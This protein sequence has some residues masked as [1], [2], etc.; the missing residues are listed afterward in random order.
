MCTKQQPWV[1]N[2]T[3]AYGFTAVSFKGGAET[4][5][6]CSCW[7]LK[8]EGKLAGKSMIVQYTNTGGDL[9][10]NHF[11]IEIPGGG[12]GVFPMGCDR[13]WNATS[14]GW[15]K[16]YG[17]DSE[18]ECKNLPAALQKGCEFR[19]N[20]MENVPNPDVTYFRV[21]CPA[22]LPAVSGC[23]FPENIE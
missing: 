21:K 10:E 4:N 5:L 20:F 3:L 7:L 15:G 23:Q 9:K 1:V 18:E 14:N 11:D 22:E 13:Q 16:R 12:T 19:F 8:F 2:K 17:I 6:C